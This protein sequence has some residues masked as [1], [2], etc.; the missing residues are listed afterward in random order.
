M[1]NESNEQPS[2][3]NAGDDL[4]FGA[5]LRGLRA[6]M[7]VFGRYTL[8]RQLGRGGMGVVWLAL[9][10][11]LDLE[12][13][14]KFVAE[15][16]VHDEVALEDLR[17][18][19]R[20]TIRLTHSNIVRV[21]DLVEEV[22]AAAIAMEYVGGRTLSGLR[23]EAASRVLEPEALRPLVGQVCEAL[24]YA[25]RV[26]RIV[27]HDLKPANIM[28]TAE[29][30]VKVMDF[31]ISSS[32]HESVSRRSRQA[33]AGHG[34]TGG[35]T[36]PYMS[37]QQL[38]GYPPSVADDVYALG[39]TLYELLAGKPPY[40]RGDVTRQVLEGVEA[41]RMA[42]RRAE[43]GIT[44]AEEIPEVWEE[45]VAA[46][47]DRDA[48]RRPARIMEVWERLN[49]PAVASLVKK[50]P[51]PKPKAFDSA[52]TASV[53]AT[54]STSVVEAVKAEIPR[55]VESKDDPETEP[56]WRPAPGWKSR[57]I[58]RIGMAVLLLAV[59]LGALMIGLFVVDAIFR[60]RRERVNQVQISANAGQRIRNE[61]EVTKRLVVGGDWKQGQIGQMRQVDLGK[62]EWVTLCYVPAG[63]FT[64]G[65]PQS[66]KGRWMPAYENKSIR[67]DPYTDEAQVEVT[68]SQSFWMGRT[69]VSQEQW[70]AVLGEKPA[71]SHEGRHL[72]VVE[73]SWDEAQRFVR[74][75]NAKALL[76]AGWEWRLPTEAQ[77]E[78]ACRAGTTT[79]YSFGAECDERLVNT[80]SVES[81]YDWARRPSLGRPAPVGSYPS[82]PWGLCDMH[83][84]AWEWCLD[85]YH[86]ELLGGMDPV[87]EDDGSG[88]SGEAPWRMGR[89]GDYIL[90]AEWC[91]SAKR[92]HARQGE[93][94]FGLRLVACSTSSHQ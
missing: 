51:D 45:V 29:G 80:T 62:S 28:V 3:P 37:P 54:G 83:G 72:P 21:Y 6:G 1:S 81:F 73:V 94:E 10:E 18:E 64:M 14:L 74:V 84:N 66:E 44:G 33:G 9:D 77:W 23:L 69:E 5:T 70:E 49:P 57:V 75:L 11:K 91:R 82:N 40:F 22:G 43:L 25:H 36:L 7:K 39:A 67:Y 78:Y 19:T 41:P 65:S 50:H 16:L 55:G 35:G 15:T 90:G 92:F 13:A 63:S 71:E 76:P 24:T 93:S 56:Q 47:L 87:R 26:A 59:L 27:H 30:Q 38:Q 58:K 12:V 17:R 48:E 32:L 60:S 61:A 8:E 88:D 52:A 4:D 79:A 20:Q 68:L 34:G 42:E 2:T 85:V 86:T 46:C 31:G 89:G 53:A